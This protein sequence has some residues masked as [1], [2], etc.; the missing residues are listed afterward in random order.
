MIPKP[1]E[2]KDTFHKQFSDL[3]V[4]ADEVGLSLWNTDDQT[5]PGEYHDHDNLWVGDGEG[6]E[7]YSSDNLED[8]AIFIMGYKAGRESM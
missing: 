4:Y 1:Q 8:L 6:T 7:M 5:E 3:T 2:V